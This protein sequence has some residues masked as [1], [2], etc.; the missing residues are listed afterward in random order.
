MPIKKQLKIVFVKNKLLRKLKKMEIPI[1][2]LKSFFL[3]NHL[4][5]QCYLLNKIII[6]SGKLSLRFFLITE[7]FA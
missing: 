7:I 1:Q 4:N 2:T 3:E 5:K 6:N